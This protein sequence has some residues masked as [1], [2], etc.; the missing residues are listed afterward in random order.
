MRVPTLLTNLILIITAATPATPGGFQNTNA[1]DLKIISAVFGAKEGSIDLTSVVSDLVKPGMNEFFATPKW[2]HF[3][4]ARTFDKDLSIVYEFRSE[5]K[6]F[7]VPEKGAVSYAILAEHAQP[8]ELAAPLDIRQDSPLKIIV[9]YFGVGGTFVEVT[10]R[11]SALIY[12]G[13]DEFVANSSSMEVNI[14]PNWTKDLIITYEFEGKRRNF[15]TPN[16]GD[17]RVSY[18]LLV[19]NARTNGMATI[20]SSV[21]P[22]WLASSRPMSIADAA[23]FAVPAPAVT[24]TERLAQ[25]NANSPNP[26]APGRAPRIEAAITALLSAQDMIR[27]DS[28]PLAIADIQSALTNARATIAYVFPPERSLQVIPGLAETSNSPGHFERIVASLSAAL[29]ELQQATPGG[30][31]QFLPSAIADTRQAIEDV[32]ARR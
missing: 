14:L 19:E 2:L 30:K 29:R 10:P 28:L 26:R 1:S 5:R 22:D 21:A 17:H 27:N 11:A 20:H 13:A 6:T 31:G 8:S 23:A 32:S 16:Y 12:P 15:F 9:A 7:T 18:D 4:P 25:E 3:D 24:A